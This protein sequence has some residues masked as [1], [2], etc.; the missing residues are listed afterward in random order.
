MS[1]ACCL[2]TA[3][4]TKAKDKST[5]IIIISNLLTIISHPL[6][7]NICI[8]INYGCEVMELVLQQVISMLEK[9]KHSTTPS[10]SDGPPLSPV[11]S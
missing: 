6:I 9:P 7:D 8:N 4:R 11:A 5:A 2:V 1:I 10:T 3:A